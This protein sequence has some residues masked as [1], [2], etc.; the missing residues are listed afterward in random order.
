VPRE[1]LPSDEKR[2]A[3]LKELRENVEYA[4]IASA[5][6][7]A[8]VSAGGLRKWEA[9]GEIER[10]SI[11][12]L[13]RYYGVY[14]KWIVEGTGPMFR[15]GEDFLTRLE[16]LEAEVTRQ[17]EALADLLG[18]DAPHPAGEQRDASNAAAAAARAGGSSARR[19]RQ[20]QS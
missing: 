1:A 8:G 15:P 18:T 13:A 11:A 20:S 14:P 4:D 17:G 19:S 16:D 3:R 10:K 7:G 9:G 12:A 2:G 6:T 5:A